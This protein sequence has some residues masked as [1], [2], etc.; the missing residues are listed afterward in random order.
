M[1][2][3]VSNLICLAAVTFVF[4]LFFFFFFFSFLKAVRHRHLPTWV[5]AVGCE[6][7]QRK[8]PCW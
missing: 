7:A 8:E 6:R 1:L 2:M 4:F 5:V 3:R